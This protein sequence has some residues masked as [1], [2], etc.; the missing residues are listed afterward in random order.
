MASSKLP[1]LGG[2]LGWILVNV[3]Q[4]HLYIKNTFELFCAS[5]LVICI[6]HFLEAQLLLASARYNASSSSVH[7][8][9]TSSSSD[10]QAPQPLSTHTKP[11]D[12]KSTII[13]GTRAEDRQSLVI[14]LIGGA[15]VTL[16]VLP[17][18]EN[19]LGI[20]GF[21]L[22]VAILLSLRDWSWLRNASTDASGFQQTSTSSARV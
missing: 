7:Q 15:A 4:L 21:C 17:P 18:N 8:T 5:I 9:P 6:Y 10:G 16:L 20:F 1:F 19:P 3:F 13:C 2:S 11:W 12:S 14:G 22:P